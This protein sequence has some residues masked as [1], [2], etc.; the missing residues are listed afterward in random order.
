[1]IVSP[2]DHCSDQDDRAFAAPIRATSIRSAVWAATTPSNLTLAGFM[3]FGWLALV[4][5]T[6]TGPDGWQARSCVQLN[7]RG[8]SCDTVRLSKDQSRLAYHSD[9]ISLAQ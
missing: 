8:P 6:G 3:I 1:M 5:W 4:A 9:I 2:T 7:F